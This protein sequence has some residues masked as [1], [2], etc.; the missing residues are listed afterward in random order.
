MSHTVVHTQAELDAALEA[1]GDDYGV[2]A[3]DSDPGVWLSVRDSRSAQVVAYDSSRVVAYESSRVVAWGS[4]RVVARESSRVEAW[5]SSRV[6]AWESSQVVAWGSS[7]VEAYGSS[8]VV[9]WESSRVV[10]RD[11]SRVVAWG[12][13]QVEAWD[14]SQVEASPHVAVHLHS[15]HATVEGGVL[16]DVIDVD[17]TTTGWCEYHGVEIRDGHAIVYK[18]V[19]DEWTTPRGFRYEPGARLVAP[20]WD[21]EYDGCGNGLHFGP[22]P[23]HARDYYPDATRY[24]EVAIPV[25]ESRPIRDGDPAKIK[26]RS[27]LV[28]G[29]V[30]IH[31]EPIGE[32]VAL[33]AA[34][35]GEPS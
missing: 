16:I 13:S 22:T 11:S 34:G 27:C 1:L 35:D 3:I 6:E 23:G 28:L 19:D 26:A 33:A 18:A 2:I 15:A 12:S 9:A 4:S 7:R 30:D 14:S 10:A 29:E 17:A 21:G 31:R 24:V 5:G 8:Q 20:D 25:T 32:H